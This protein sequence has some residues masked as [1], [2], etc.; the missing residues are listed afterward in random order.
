MLLDDEYDRRVL[1]RMRRDTGRTTEPTWAEQRGALAGAARDAGNLA[2]DIMLPQGPADL[3]LMAAF[4][5]GGRM[6]R[7]PAAAGLLAM[8]AGDAEAGSR[9][10]ARGVARGAARAARGGPPSAETPARPSR[11][12]GTLGV[13]PAE[14]PPAPG[15]TP[16]TREGTAAPEEIN[17]VARESREGMTQP[18]LRAEYRRLGLTGYEPFPEAVPS[19]RA[20]PQAEIERATRMKLDD[21]EFLNTL[22]PEDR[23]LVR[24]GQHRTL[25]LPSQEAAAAGRAETAG[26]RREVT[27]AQ[28]DVRRMRAGQNDPEQGVVFDLSSARLN[29]QPDVPQFDLPRVAPRETDRLAGLS[30]SGP[31]RLR[32]AA[33]RGGEWSQGWYNL[34][35][36]REGF[37]GYHGPERGDRLF[38]T[39]LDYVAGTSMVNPIESNLRTATEYLGRTMRGEPLPMPLNV[40]DPQTGRTVQTLAAPPPW[41][42]GAKSQVQHAARAREFASGDIDAVD[43]AKPFSY[44]MNLGGNWRPTTVDTHEIRNYVGRDRFPLF[45]EEGNGALLPGEYSLIEGAGSRVAGRMGM[46]PAQRQAATWVG[47]GEYTGLVSPPVPALRAFED[48][49]LVTSRVRGQSPTQVLEDFIREGR[50]LLSAAPVGVGIGAGLLGA[51]EEEPIQ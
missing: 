31:R 27:R 5:P 2:A 15:E 3:A 12:R 13:E 16:V 11:R 47:G 18:Q 17:R 34:D 46:S 39:F 9:E 8:E 35:Q 41:P 48:R 28:D 1:A 33:E 51:P 36:L 30:S 21:R 49:V 26:L 23:R 24:E 10:V 19:L 4:G 45:G 6:L 43:N 7:I 38:S 42:Y 22:S 50:P 29:Q 32:E 37:R 20:P 40:A 25:R 14:P 44:R